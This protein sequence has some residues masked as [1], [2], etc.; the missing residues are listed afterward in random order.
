MSTGTFEFRKKITTASYAPPAAAATVVAALNAP[1]AAGAAL[2][3]PEIDFPAL[4]S[5][6]DDEIKA[7]VV[8]ACML[9]L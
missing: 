1:A 6:G 9:A 5:L 2:V 4:Q 8:S 7:R 3:F